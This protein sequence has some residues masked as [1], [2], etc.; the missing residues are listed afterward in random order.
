M[1][2][3]FAATEPA[4]T[5]VVQRG[6]N[7]VIERGGGPGW[8]VPLLIALAVALVAAI[9]LY[10]VSWRFKKADVDRETALQAADVVD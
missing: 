2:G 3:S 1:S 5:I 6:A 9:A 7:L 8:W 4:R 10:S